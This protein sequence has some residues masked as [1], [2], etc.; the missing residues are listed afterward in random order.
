[1]QGQTLQDWLLTSSL[2]VRSCNFWWPIQI[3]YSTNKQWHILTSKGLLDCAMY[4]LKKLLCQA[5]QKKAFTNAST[6][7]KNIDTLLRFGRVCSGEHW[8]ASYTHQHQS[9]LPAQCKLSHALLWPDTF[10]IIQPEKSL[11]QNNSTIIN[12]TLKYISG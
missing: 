11:Y 7:K 4:G 9:L 5:W 6:I 3:C 1:M 8:W 12:N 2:N 10:H